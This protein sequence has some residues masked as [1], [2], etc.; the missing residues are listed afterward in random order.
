MACTHA[1][2][3]QS[4]RPALHRNQRKAVP[5]PVTGWGSK[6]RGAPS[7]F[8][9]AL[10]SN[11]TPPRTTRMDASRCSHLLIE[12]PLLST[13]ERRPGMQSANAVVRLRGRRE[14]HVK[15]RTVAA[16]VTSP[17]APCAARPHS[18]KQR[19]GSHNSFLPRSHLI[20]SQQHHLVPVRHLLHRFKARHRI[21][22]PSLVVVY[23]SSS[24]LWLHP[25]IILLCLSGSS[26]P[27]GTIS[28][29]LQPCYLPELRPPFLLATYITQPIPP[30][31][32]LV[33][34]TL[35]SLPPLPNQSKP[36]L[37]P[38]ILHPPSPTLHIPP[39]PTHTSLPQ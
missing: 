19:L 39:P 29:L 16:S 35:V 10:N 36:S 20:S 21:G 11:P 18:L 23:S 37:T 9:L 5:V 1:H 12:L 30:S 14:G 17:V 33:D 4:R 7:A 27:P 6:G 28:A 8:S 31:H 3:G 13:A 26:K 2:L 25:V 15:R 24:F 38:S 22:S 32:S 34:L